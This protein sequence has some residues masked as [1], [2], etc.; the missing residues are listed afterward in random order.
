MMLAE[1]VTENKIQLIDE[2]LSK[3]TRHLTV[4]LED[5]YQE[6]NASAVIRTCDCFGVQDLY[7]T[8]DLHQYNINPNVV[9]G[10]SKWVNIHRYERGQASIASCFEELKMKGY[11]IV[12]TTPDPNSASIYDLPI[13]QRTAVV[14]GTEKRG[15]S[16]FARENV[17]ELV[18][19]PMLGFT[20]SF[21]IS[22]STALV[23]NELST[24][25]RNS[26]TDWQLTEV[27]KDELRLCWYKQIVKRSDLL[28]N[29][30]K[31]EHS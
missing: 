9:R 26:I 24:R 8:E 23:L 22:V 3:R 6:Q 14:F 31:R 29:N 18:H 28:I 19:I 10:A 27:E 7:I 20:E 12:G 13:D 30:F 4:V 25:L 2:V 1:Y 21:N 15:M 11:R 17:D 5:I 16:D